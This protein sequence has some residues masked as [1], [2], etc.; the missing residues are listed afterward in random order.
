LREDLRDFLLPTH[1]DLQPGGLHTWPTESPQPEEYAPEDFRALQAEV[2]DL[3]AVVVA[4]RP[5]NEIWPY[6]PIQ[7]SGA[8]PHVSS[9]PAAQPGRHFVSFQGATRD[10]F[11][12]RIL[13]LLGQVNTA[14]LRRCPECDTVFLRNRNQAYCSRT[15]VNRVT[16]RRWR[17]RQ[18]AAPTAEPSLLPDASRAE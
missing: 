3:L 17:E 9:L 5:T 16:Q 18:D 6:K 11:L 2:R 8:A 13:R 4:S 7:V 12:L 10:L 15:C 14:G 1:A